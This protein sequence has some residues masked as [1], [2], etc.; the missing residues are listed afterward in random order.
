MQR[1]V[2]RRLHAGQDTLEIRDIGIFLTPA[3][4]LHVGRTAERLHVSAARASQAIK[5]RV[6]NVGAPLRVHQPRR[7]AHTGRRTPS[8]R[9]PAGLRRASHQ[10]ES[11]PISRSGEDRRA[12]H[13]HG[14][15]QHDS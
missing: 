10:H 6:R 12:A 3:E 7:T 5:K 4:D 13:R 9:P 14:R 15:Q 1:C 11:G 2:N 8:P